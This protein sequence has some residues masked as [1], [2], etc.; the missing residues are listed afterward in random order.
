MTIDS[1]TDSTG[2]FSGSDSDSDSKGPGASG[3]GSTSRTRSAKAR[4]PPRP[5]TRATKKADTGPSPKRKA[6]AKGNGK[7]AKGKGQAAKGKG[8]GKKVKPA[9]SSVSG[10]MRYLTFTCTVLCAV[11]KRI[12][13]LLG[14]RSHQ[15]A[16][17]NRLRLSHHPWLPQHPR[18]ERNFDAAM[19]FAQGQWALLYSDDVLAGGIP[20]YIL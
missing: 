7:A 8:K 18:K 1:D 2:S 16:A 3:G 4:T 6:K 11:I 13:R 12:Q 20:E 15:L 9:R 17:K 5:A 14:K 10:H 19:A